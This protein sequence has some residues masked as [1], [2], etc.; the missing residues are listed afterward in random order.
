MGIDIGK[1]LAALGAGAST[2]GAYMYR[3]EQEKLDR[4]QRDEEWKKREGIAAKREETDRQRLAVQR[5]VQHDRAL[6]DAYRDTGVVGNVPA[7]LERAYK[8]G[9]TRAVGDAEYNFQGDPLEVLSSLDPFGE[10]AG[11]DER[12][13]VRDRL[14][15]KIASARTSSMNLLPSLAKSIGTDEFS[16]YEQQARS[17]VE[18]MDGL[19][20][21]PT[22]DKSFEGASKDVIRTQL[23]KNR[24]DAM[25][26]RHETP[27][28][29]T[30]Y[31]R[32]K[33]EEDHGAEGRGYYEKYSSDPVFLTKVGEYRALEQQRTGV[34]M[35]EEEAAY[36]VGKNYDK[37]KGAATKKGKAPTGK[38]FSRQS[39]PK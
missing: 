10:P 32:D 31:N 28:G 39:L 11:E 27:S 22:R 4:E 38:S 1:I 18:L 29:S 3:G 14:D 8:T 17:P 33:K 37:E 6:Q 15:S 35:S 23:A 24:D 5:R 9:V 7:I 34:L 12:Q 25:Q 19:Q 36:W 26:A 20:Y 30:V 21:V 13:S 2:Y 16:K